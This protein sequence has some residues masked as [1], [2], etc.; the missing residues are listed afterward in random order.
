MPPK[1]IGDVHMAPAAGAAGEQP[2]TSK[3]K[4]GAANGGEASSPL[5]KLGQ[6]VSASKRQVRSASPRSSQ[7][8]EGLAAPGGCPISLPV[9]SPK[10]LSSTGLAGQL[11]TLRSRKKRSSEGERCAAKSTKVFLTLRHCSTAPQGGAATPGSRSSSSAQ[12][13]SSHF[14]GLPGR[15]P[16]G[17]E[18]SSVGSLGSPPKVTARCLIAM[19]SR[20][21]YERLPQTG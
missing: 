17:L 19:V 2:P 16:H 20:R 3:Q 21:S 5:S 1:P 4:G 13:F 15:C 11:R 10:A 6:R 18:V 14:A 7:E 9:R 12:A 8:Q